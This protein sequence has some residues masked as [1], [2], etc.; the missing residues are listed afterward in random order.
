MGRRRVL[1]EEARVAGLV[2]LLGRE[3]ARWDEVMSRLAY[4]PLDQHPER[5]IALVEAV[6][7]RWSP[8][9]RDLPATVLRQLGAGEVRPCLRLVRAVDL[10][11]LWAMPRRDRLFARMIG[12]GGVR[13]LYS[14]TTRYDHGTPHVEL[15]AAH[16]TG[17]RVLF[18]GMSGIQAP[19]ARLIASSPAFAG[20]ASLSLHNNAIDDEGALAL[21]ESPHLDRLGYLNLYGNRI[22]ADVIA[23]IA[24]A[25]QW[26]R[27]VLILHG[28]N[29]WT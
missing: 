8:R 22:S 1:G 21:V 7:E 16:V 4:W 12:E 15:L 6:A 27:A 26:R 24:C 13:E 20:L 11:P 23:R 9:A 14:F 25:P 2:E 19:A 28:Q 17:L 18:L 3:A 29:L 5:G 10:R